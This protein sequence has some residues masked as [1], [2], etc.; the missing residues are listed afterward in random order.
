MIYHLYSQ[1]CFP[2]NL[3]DLTNILNLFSC[4]VSIF[5]VKIFYQY[6]SILKLLYYDNIGE[7]FLYL[8][9]QSLP[10][11][12]YMVSSFTS[13]N[14]VSQSSGSPHL[15]K[16]LCQSYKVWFLCCTLIRRS[17]KVYSISCIL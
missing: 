10:M 11:A 3:G 13:F 15:H 12:S 1:R 14:F 4:L 8:F 17:F 16:S 9:T 6:S 2:L 7:Q 5:L